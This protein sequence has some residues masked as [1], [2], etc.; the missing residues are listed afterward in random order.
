VPESAY[1]NVSRE[2]AIEINTLVIGRAYRWIYA[3]TSI[4]SVTSLFVGDPKN[5]RMD[6]DFVKGPNLIRLRSLLPWDV[7]EERSQ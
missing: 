2:R 7:R 5:V 4:E 3:P 1:R 6:V